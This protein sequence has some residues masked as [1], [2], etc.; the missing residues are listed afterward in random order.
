MAFGVSLNADA[1]GGEQLPDSFTRVISF[2]G[3]LALCFSFLATFPEDAS[4][5]DNIPNLTLTPQNASATLDSGSEKFTVR[6]GMNGSTNHIKLWVRRLDGDD[7]QQEE[8]DLPSTSGLS[9]SREV[10]FSSL[11]S[12]LVYGH[13]YR[14]RVGAY[15]TN[16]LWNPNHYHY[17]SW[18]DAVTLPCG[19]PQ[20]GQDLKDD[21]TVL[22][23]LY[24]SAGGA[25]WTDKTNWASAN[26]LDTWHGIKVSSGR[27]TEINLFENNLSGSIPDISDL[28]GLK[29]LNI[30]GNSNLSG[31]VPDI[32]S[33]TSLQYLDL[34]E[35]N[36]SGTI[37]T[38]LNSLTNLRRI[39][40]ASNSLSGEI[41]DLSSLASLEQL[42]LNE[43]SLGGT[44]DASELPTSLRSLVLSHNELSGTIPTGLSSLTSLEELVLRDNDLSGEIPDLSALTS[45][46]NLWL[47]NNDLS[48][49]VATSSFPT[50]LSSL[51]LSNNELSGTIPDFTDFA[52]NLMELWLDNNDLAGT[53]PATLDNLTKLWILQLNR[54]TLSGELPD[55]SS[56]AE[57]RY[58]LVGHNSL[59]GSLPD[60]SDFKWI[61]EFR[62]NN[63]DFSGSVDSR[64][65]DS[66]AIA[67]VLDLSN[68]TNL[69]GTL[70]LSLKDVSEIHT[71]RINCTGIAVP[72]DNDFQTWLTGLGTNYSGPTCTQGN[73]LTPF[74]QEPSPP[75]GGRGFQPVGEQD[76]SLP[77]GGKISQPDHGSDNSGGDGEEELIFEEEPETEA[78]PSVPESGPSVPGAGEAEGGGCTVASD[79]G[80]GISF[81]SGAVGL[82]MGLALLTLLAV[83][84][85]GR[86][87]KRDASFR[88][89]GGA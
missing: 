6:W 3:A 15:Y 64:G 8:K 55:L 9:T 89:C 42:W 24:S 35:N 51:V 33:L 14:F 81:T 56:L 32:S 11:G 17:S 49:T 86:R 50:S 22:M 82:N 80:T 84:W 31:T 23:N 71:L 59:S 70:P 83:S 25:N 85:R 29:K 67:T 26:S 19:D 54:N 65:L 57:L 87:S 58:L 77:V 45:L 5:H 46:S 76:S 10:S 30:G 28:T 53:I 61:R 34:Y 39:W 27:V 2:L 60:L 75:V 36:L 44:V 73:T 12:S 38:A 37:P 21:C 1:G 72:T 63:N 62:V 13:K 78:R 40:L 4:G 47:L 20:A 48:G 7:N 88:P 43:N 52:D 69:S 18:T 68:N 79:S 66:L 74:G 41:P 16:I